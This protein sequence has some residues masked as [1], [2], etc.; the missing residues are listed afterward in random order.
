MF[1]SLDVL[2]ARKGDCLILHYGSLAKP[3]LILI[4]GGPSSVYKPH[5]KPR[6]EQIR[7]ARNLKKDQALPVDALMVSHVDD[8]HIKGVLELTAELR[9]AKSSK[10]PLPLRIGDLW[11]NSFDKVLKTTLEQLKGTAQFGVASLGAMLGES[12]PVEDEEQLAMAMVLASIPQGHQL[13]TDAQFLNLT[14]NSG[15][16]TE[17]AMATGKPEVVKLGGT[18]KFTVVGPMQRELQAL[19]DKHDEW[20]R[21]QKEKG[22]EAALAAYTDASV[23]N[24]SSIVLHAEVNGKTMLLTGDARGDKVLEGLELAGLAKPGRELEVDV[25][26]VPHH[27]SAHNVEKEFF[28]RIKAKEYVFSGNGEHGNPERETLE[29]LGEARGND[30][31]VMHFTYPID[32]IDKAR[33]ADWNKEREKARKKGKI[34]PPWSPERDSL[35]GYFRRANIPNRKQ[36]IRIV[37]DGKP[38]VLD[39]LDPIGF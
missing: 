7:R 23:P 36:Q 17:L 8:D 31:F 25:L 35:A 3:G 2:R 12:E 32:E 27:G 30:S 6:L 22:A 13:R 24:L 33:E 5:L 26:K 9:D 14:V 39:L 10:R 16:G 37:E 18:L 38:H 21:K 1:F 28:K 15:F 20:V 29:M 19:Q 34:K 11:H 4:D